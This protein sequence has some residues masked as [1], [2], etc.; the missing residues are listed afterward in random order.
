MSGQELIPTKN[1][2][3]V[4]TLSDCKYN[5]TINNECYIL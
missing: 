1:E 2:A 3:L 5:T 4:L